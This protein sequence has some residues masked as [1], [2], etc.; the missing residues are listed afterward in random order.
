MPFFIRYAFGFSLDFFNVN[1]LYMERCRPEGRLCIIYLVGIR[2][3]GNR[4]KPNCLREQRMDILGNTQKLLSSRI[5]VA[6][7]GTA[8]CN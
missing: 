6:P 1:G 5:E 7:L 3:S 2:F 8:L 4:N